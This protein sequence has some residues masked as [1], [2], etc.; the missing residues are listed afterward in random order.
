MTRNER[1][2]RT[3]S[4]VKRRVKWMKWSRWWSLDAK[5]VG[6]CK[7]KHPNDCGR[8]QCGCCR[9]VDGAKF[10]ALRQTQHVEDWI[11]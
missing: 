3:A 7:S 2:R 6:M 4:V 9:C 10:K 1:R 8:T 5:T 11:E